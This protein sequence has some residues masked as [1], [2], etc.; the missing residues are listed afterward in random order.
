MSGL[1]SKGMP[2]ENIVKM[3]LMV[4]QAQ[5]QRELEQLKAVLEGIDSAEIEKL[6]NLW[7][8]LVLHYESD[9]DEDTASRMALS[10]FTGILSAEMDG[11]EA[12]YPKPVLEK[13]IEQGKGN[14][15][16]SGRSGT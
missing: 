8:H 13:L 1:F 10:N 6:T 2:P 11:G 3:T 16:K 7:L 14:I 15:L 9:Y 12:N 5:K 4:L